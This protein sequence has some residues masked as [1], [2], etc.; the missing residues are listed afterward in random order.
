MLDDLKLTL[1]AGTKVKRLSSAEKTLVQIA[2]ELSSAQARIFVID[3]RHR[4][5][6]MPRSWSCYEYWIPSES[7]PRNSLHFPSHRRS[8]RDCRQN[9][10]S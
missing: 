9:R 4:L 8:V 6:E 2:K 10:Q 3:E 1:F 7:A 5:S